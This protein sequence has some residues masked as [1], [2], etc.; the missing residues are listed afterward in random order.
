M[1]DAACA[2]I[3]GCTAVLS[4]LVSA[5]DARVEATGRLEQMRLSMKRAVASRVAR[6]GEWREELLASHRAAMRELHDSSSALDRS[7][8]AWMDAA[9]ARRRAEE[10]AVRRQLSQLASRLSASEAAAAALND[11][12]S[13]L[14]RTCEVAAD[15]RHTAE[16]AR[17][18]DTSVLLAA[19][20]RLERRCDASSSETKSSVDA[21]TSLD[22]IRTELREEAMLQRLNWQARALAQLKTAAA[23]AA[24]AALPSLP[25]WKQLCDTVAQL[26]AASRLQQEWNEA[27]E[28]RRSDS[29]SC[30]A[31]WERR[32]ARQT[33]S[34]L[35]LARQAAARVEELQLQLEVQKV[36]RQA[37]SGV[38]ADGTGGESGD[39]AAEDGG[40]A[41]EGKAD[42]LRVQLAE[43]G[44]RLSCVEE[45]VRIA[46]DCNASLRSAA[47]AV[48]RSAAQ[49]P[50]AATHQLLGR[51][52]KDVASQ[53]AAMRSLS[54]DV[55]FAKQ[56]AVTAG[57]KRK[58]LQAAIALQ[59][60][61]A[62]A[63][64][65]LCVAVMRETEGRLA[66]MLREEAGESERAVREVRADV[67]AA[68]GRLSALLVERW[69]A[70]AFADWKAAVDR[71]RGEGW[72]AR[73][74]SATPVI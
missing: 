8:A 56:A 27:A 57:K 42:E 6:D 15:A 44:E 40:A 2:A 22:S 11:R 52:A 48:A 43:M 59:G 74:T 68:H 14:A 72:S 71:V 50:A 53:A 18:R 21:S 7:T 41:V 24:T 32:W 4:E 13:Q 61:R 38:V 5:A 28:K 30:S 34:A 39:G 17:L 37:R 25:A 47:S 70:A 58:Q 12:V 64:R 69:Q 62:V 20:H 60:Q 19:V 51:L 54:A 35:Q 67:S 23:E 45:R 10:E 3:D 66:V 29:E 31:E 65:R 33:S 36:G 9:A 26:T 1:E 63:L 55:R 16:A 46:E 73:R 49:L